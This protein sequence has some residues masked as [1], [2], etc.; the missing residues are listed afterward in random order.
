MFSH[1]KKGQAHNRGQGVRKAEGM[2]EV[3]GSLL[4]RH[5]RKSGLE[6]EPAEA[7]QWQ[8]ASCQLK[9]RSCPAAEGKQG[10]CPCPPFP[11]RRKPFAAR[12]ASEKLGQAIMGWDVL[13]AP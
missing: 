4:L 6:P 13:L 10:L 5:K 9:I 11:G 1:A 8:A 2:E 12:L 7:K 3:R